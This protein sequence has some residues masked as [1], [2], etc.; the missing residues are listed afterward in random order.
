[1]IP[2]KDENPKGNVP[3]VNYILIIINILVFYKQPSLLN[4]LKTFFNTFGVVP[5]E[6]SH[7][8]THIKN[9]D[10]SVILTT[11]TS[12][13]IHGGL[14]HLIG[15][16]LFLWIFG[17]NIEYHIGHI[18]YL[19]FYLSCGLIATLSQVAV[20]PNSTIPVVG[21]SGAISGVMGAYLIK[22]PKNK[23]TVLFIFFIF[24]RFIK[25]PAAY[26]LSFWFIYQMGHGLLSYGEP[27]LGGVAWFAH[28]GGFLGGLFLIKLIE[29]GRY[30][31][32]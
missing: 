18:R 1:M 15:N 29:K 19:I 9:G 31:V 2:I 10:Y 25:I 30:K 6:L 12:I 26:V 8:I 7:I 13:F 14:L 24:I 32:F 4:D 11:I 27:S 16:M 5:N 17:D 21:A 3:V 28:I 22:Y 20:D 23:V